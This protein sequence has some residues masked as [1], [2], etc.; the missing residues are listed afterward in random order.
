MKPNEIT[1]DPYE[2]REIVASGYWD[3]PRWK[4]VQRLRSTGNPN[5]MIHSNGLMGE[6]YRDW[7]VD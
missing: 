3:D 7:G 4:E 1:T 6:I 2:Q 5:D